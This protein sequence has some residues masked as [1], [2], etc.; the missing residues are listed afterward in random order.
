MGAIAPNP[1]QPRAYFDEEALASLTAS[2]AELGVLQPILV[3]E[4]GDERY[5]LIAGER[6]WRAAKRAGLPS[7][8]VVVRTVDEVLSLEQALVENLHRADLNPLE[9]AAAY[10]QLIEDFGLTQE[11]V[12]KRVG[13]SRAAISNTLRLFQLPPAIQALVAENQLT[14]GHARALLGTPDRAYQTAL[15]QRIVREGLSVREAEEAV[16]LRSG[17]SPVPEPTPRPD[18]PQKATQRERPA[19]DPAFL[20]LESL[21]GDHL[22]TRVSISGGTGGKGRL[23]VEFADLVDLERIYRRMAGA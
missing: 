13:K 5:E 23:V 7:I 22:D 8:P 2:V 16:R 21:L 1:H 15:A 12:A 6:R 4:I 9:E 17:D 10:Q 14:A 3:R 11:A 20:E 19:A 18:S